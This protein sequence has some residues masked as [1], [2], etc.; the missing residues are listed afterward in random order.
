[1]IK[2]DIMKK[3]LAGFLS[4]A[5]T[6]T[7]LPV[8]T[9]G[10]VQ[11]AENGPKPVLH[12]DMSHA[13]GKL[14]DISGNHLD[15]K[16]QGITDDDFVTSDAGVELKFD[17][18]SKYVEIPAGVIKDGG[19]YENP[20][21]GSE[22]A[23]TIEA[24]YTTEKQSAAWLFTLGTTVA[25]WP[26]VQ[27]YLFVAPWV[28]DGDYPGKMLAAIK[29]DTDEKRYDKDTALEGDNGGGKN[30]VS[31]VF[32]NGE[33]TYYLNGNKSAPTVSGFKIQDIL[34]ANS[35]DTCIGY[36]GKSLYRPDPDFQGKVLDFKIY[37][38]A[39]TETQ[40]NNIHDD[41]VNAWESE[42]KIK[43]VK[44]SI[45]NTMLN[46]NESI[47]EVSTNLSFPADMEGVALTWTSSKPAVI[48]A[49]GTVNA[50]SQAQKV[51]VSVSGTYKDKSFEES[52]ELK[53]INPEG[54]EYEALTIPNASDITGNITLPS[55]G[56]KGSDITWTSSDEN[57]IGTAAIGQM[58]AGVVTRDEGTDKNVTLT[59]TIKQASG[60]KEKIFNVKVR[61][62]AVVGTMTDY[63]FAYFAG[64]G[65]GEQIHL[66]ISRDGLS[67]EELNKGEPILKSEMGT[68]GLRDP[69]ILRSPEGD[70]FYLVATDLSIAAANWDWDSVQ[71]RGSQAVMV[72]ESDDLVHWTNQRM[73]VVSA[74]VEAG[75]TW[76]PEVFYDDTTGEYML[77]WS[78]KVKS[79]NYDK[80]R[81]YYC[82]TRDF[83]TFTEPKIWIENTFS[84]IDTTVIRGEDGKYYRFSKNE[85][86]GAKYIYEEVADT[87]LG[88]WKGVGW[89]TEPK[90]IGGGE[91]PC[92][93]RFND[94]DQAKA[95]AKYCL[96]IDD[97][98]GVRYYPMITNDLASGEF[99]DAKDTADEYNALLDAY[100]Y[101]S[102]APGS[103]PSYVTAGY[104]L[105]AEVEIILCGEKRKVSVTWDKTA[106]DFAEVGEVEVTGT[107]ASIG[108]KTIT[109]TIEVI[110]ASDKLLYFI[111]CGVGAWNEK[112]STSGYY[113]AVKSK[114]ELRNEVP[115]QL[116]T[117]GSWGIVNPK[118]DSEDGYRI[119]RLHEWMVGKRW[120]VM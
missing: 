40:V 66:A 62:K 37:D 107:I 120:K 45:L 111:D 52:W 85:D 74:Q 116:Y 14:T 92:C 67:W 53:V 81:V 115:D 32:D 9:V 69:Y 16:L 28:S 70:K 11:A 100:A 90:E 2:K 58:P 83:Y 117:Q 113:E 94:D 25:E 41:K 59:A 98:G 109:K 17:G 110:S 77:F 61:K 8:N 60:D 82:K 97:F 57:V 29:N 119:F 79:N 4:F 102:L 87:L 65:E 10:I 5:M 104:T 54:A 93:F 84:T 30:I 72:W 48:A 3:C 15:G 44:D 26:N 42:K 80:Q 34:E 96:L 20:S 46:G 47:N 51:T 71:K 23:F 56:K 18:T 73:A 22:E 12:Y 31:V 55:K 91:G 63:V 88:E 35:T 78:S 108:N 75:C 103:L 64:D 86:N 106:D 21:A 76:A 38:Q 49:D 114:V 39:L 118:D 50:T 24:T 43:K 68:K 105:P 89:T 36:I 7:L 101:P 112:L 33:V 95:G 13:D 99:T 27:N 1:M 6:A 19:S